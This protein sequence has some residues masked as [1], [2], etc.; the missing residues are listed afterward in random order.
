[1]R[2]R[3]LNATEEE[4]AAYRGMFGSMQQGFS[5]TFDHLAQY[6]AKLQGSL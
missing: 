6:L 4:R 1:V 3:P 2:G 5:G